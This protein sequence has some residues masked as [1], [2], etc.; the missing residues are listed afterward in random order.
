MGHQ[1]RGKSRH[2]SIEGLGG[3]G[4]RADLP[5][6]FREAPAQRLQGQRGGRIGG[7][8]DVAEDDAGAIPVEGLGQAVREG[9]LSRAQGHAKHG[10]QPIQEICVDTQLVDIELDVEQ[11]AGAPRVDPIRGRDLG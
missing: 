4:L 9:H 5:E 10:V 3:V 7:Q 2:I 1:A 8:N 11:E 6:A